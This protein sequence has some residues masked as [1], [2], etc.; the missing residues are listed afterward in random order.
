MKYTVGELLRQ[1]QSLADGNTP[2]TSVEFD[3]CSKTAC[4]AT[5]HRRFETWN[6]AVRAAGYTPVSQTY[7]KEKLIDQINHLVE[8]E[9]PPTWQDFNECP[10][11]AAAKTITD[12]FGSYREGIRAAGYVPRQEQIEFDKKELITALHRAASTG[13]I[14]Q[15]KYN[16]DSN[17]D[18]PSPSTYKNHFG[19]IPVAA[20]RGS[21]DIDCSKRHRAVPLTKTEL[22][23]FISQIPKVDP[24]DQATAIVSLLT[25]CTHNEHN[26]VDRESIKD[27]KTDSVILFPSKAERGGRSISIGAL[28]NQLVREFDSIST[29]RLN[30][31]ISFSNY[32]F[33]KEDARG[34]LRRLSR[35][36]NFDVDRQVIGGQKSTV[37]PQVLHRDIRC[38]HYLFERCRGASQA[39]LKRRLALSDSEIRHYHRFLDNPENEY[40]WSVKIDW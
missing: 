1:I 6:K 38:T 31:S 27:T 39:M 33:R 7:S 13:N 35:A 23:Q 29:E 28:Y 18:F 26:W 37:G 25:G 40:G 5:I 11:T 34:S 15:L 32:P 17:C 8:G 4:S 20:I 12:K 21:I 22:K 24:I 19:G 36:V 16:R 14:K 3:K 9:K 10:E 2:P 30:Q